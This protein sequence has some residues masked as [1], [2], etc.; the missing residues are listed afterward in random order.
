MHVQ[1]LGVKIIYLVWQCY[2]DDNSNITNIAIFLY[3]ALVQV[4]A[5]IL[6]IQTRRVKVKVLNDSKYIV[7]L[8][9][10]SSVVLLLL[11][12]VTFIQG[13]L[14]NVNEMLVSGALLVSTTAFLTLTF[15]PKVAIMI[16]YYIIVDRHQP[17]LHDSCMAEIK[18]HQPI[19]II[20]DMMCNLTATNRW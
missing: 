7:A 1:E 12:I 11:I 9:Y 19:C 3:L 4:A 18:E 6:A 5:I 14:I 13:A 17:F 10:I 16:F 8:I 20:I 2:S 15:I